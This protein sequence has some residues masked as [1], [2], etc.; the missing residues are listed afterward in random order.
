MLR[1]VSRELPWRPAS[2]GRDAET[3]EEIIR[4]APS[5]L[6]SRDRAVT[7]TDF[8]I[9]A[10]EAS[11][12]VARAACDGKMGADGTVEVSVAVTNTGQRSGDEVVQLYVHE[13]ASA[14]VRPAK[15]LRGFRRITLKP[16]EKLT[17]TLALPAAKLAY[18]DERTHAF[19]VKPGTFEIMVGASSADIRAKGAVEVVGQ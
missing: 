13:V 9:I 18:W 2:G 7:A 11:G 17:V 14:V 5:L 15:E 12:E 4:R 10:R 19:V 8:A 1:S 6:T 16:G 3:I